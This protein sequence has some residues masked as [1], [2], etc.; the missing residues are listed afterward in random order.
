MHSLLSA[1][2]AHPIWAPLYF[3]KRLLLQRA[4]RFSWTRKGKEEEEGWFFF[5]PLPPP[6][7]SP[8][9]PQSS[10]SSIQP[11][12]DGGAEE[13]EEE[14]Q[15]P[16]PPSPVF[17]PPSSSSRRRRRKNPAAAQPT[18]GCMVVLLLLLP[19]ILLRLWV[20]PTT[21]L[22]LLLSH[23]PILLHLLLF[24]PAAQMAAWRWE[25]EVFFAEPSSFSFEKKNTRRNKGK[26]RSRG[27]LWSGN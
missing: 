27:L 10:S 25:R 2:F 22:F 3:A 11:N 12:C 21:P 17:P 13:E 8:P 9:Q 4:P 24:L 7:H 15:P 5:P 20:S 6:S 19:E 14:R 26:R 1:L 23:R 18:P 16:P